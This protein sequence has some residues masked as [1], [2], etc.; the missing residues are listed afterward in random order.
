[1]RNRFRKTANWFGYVIAKFKLAK[2]MSKFDPIIY[3]PLHNYGRKGGC[4]FA[5]SIV[6]D[7]PKCAFCK[8]FVEA[9]IPRMR[10]AE[11]TRA[12]Y[13]M[14]KNLYDSIA[15]SNQLI[16]LETKIKKYKDDG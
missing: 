9:I 8:K 13:L 7:Y 4:E 16:R 15:R 12:N 1:M 14:A 6:C 2:Y 10:I 5:D 11:K 3:C